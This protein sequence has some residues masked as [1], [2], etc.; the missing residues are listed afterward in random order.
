MILSIHLRFMHFN[1][2]TSLSQAYDTSMPVQKVSTAIWGT[3]LL[4]V[5]VPTFNV[6]RFTDSRRFWPRFQVRGAS[7]KFA[8]W[9]RPYAWKLRTT[10]R[11]FM[12][13][14]IWQ[15]YEK[16][17][18]CF[19]CHFDRICLITTL[20]EDLHALLRI[21]RYLSDRKI[22]W[23]K[24]ADKNET[25]ILGALITRQYSHGLQAGRPGFDSR[26]GQEILLHSVQTDSG[27]H[28]A[29]YS[30]GTEGSFPGG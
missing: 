14:H 7:I 13:S 24:A 10:G 26:K 27:A 22:L 1:T 28:P 30:M 3:I 5:V 2:N 29:S 23:T 18:N 16:L 20:H 9:V 8:Q 6:S 21:C 19:Y 17:S 12:K 4:P 25:R 11:I 15:H